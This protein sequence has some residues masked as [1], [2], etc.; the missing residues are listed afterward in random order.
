MASLWSR[1]TEVKNESNETMVVKVTRDP[2]NFKVKEF[3]IPAGDYIYMCYND[4]GIEHNPDRPVN[5]R[6]YVGDEQKLY[7]RA[8]RIRD[9]GKIVLGY[10]N[11]M[12]TS[13]FIDIYM[14]A[15]IGL[16]I[17]MKGA[18]KKIKKLLGK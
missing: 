6:V 3:I 2:G 15:R 8:S 1:N 17:K 10:E 7:V 5:V 14:V 16:I 9:S 13:T 11:G 18:T 4:F 12:V